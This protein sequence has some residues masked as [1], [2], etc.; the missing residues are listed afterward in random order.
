MKN[1]I[2]IPKDVTDSSS[3]AVNK[4]L[5]ATYNVYIDIKPS[6]DFLSGAYVRYVLN[7]PYTWGSTCSS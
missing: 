6:V 7:T 3:V 4:N 5:E 2:S 1:K